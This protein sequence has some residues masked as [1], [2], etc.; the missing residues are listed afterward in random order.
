MALG[1]PA[2][3]SAVVKLS[4]LFPRWKATPEIAN[5]VVKMLM[6]VDLMPEQ[7]DAVIERH[8]IESGSKGDPD[9]AKI[10]A[11][12]LEIV[13]SESVDQ[14]CVARRKT[15]QQE[16]QGLAFRTFREFAIYHRDNATEYYQ[17]CSE[18]IRKRLDYLCSDEYLTIVE[19]EKKK[20]RRGDVGVICSDILPDS[21]PAS[22]SDRLKEIWTLRTPLSAKYLKG[23]QR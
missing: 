22:K 16:T 5:V 13:R 23:N 18:T 8:K 20:Q 3:Q 19:E 1:E 11:R 7:V 6:R 14:E 12:L 9:L 4:K 21:T 10:Q 17:T 15:L 2:A